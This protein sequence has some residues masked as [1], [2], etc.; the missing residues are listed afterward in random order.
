M[1]EK[2]ITV[3]ETETFFSRENNQYHK[4]IQNTYSEN[5]F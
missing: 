4:S 2:M 1:A 3:R 5:P